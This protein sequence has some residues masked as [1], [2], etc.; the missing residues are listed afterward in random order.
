MTGHNRN[1]FAVLI[2]V[3]V[4]AGS[5][6]IFHLSQQGNYAPALVYGDVSTGSMTRHLGVLLQDVVTLPPLIPLGIR[7]YVGFFLATSGLLIAAGGGIGG[8]GMLVPIYNMIIGFPIKY[9]IA[10]ASI[11]VFGGAVA[12][13][14]LNASKPHPLHKVR[15]CI[16][17]ELILQMEP[18]TMAGALIGATLNK[19]LPDGPLVVL[20][21]VVLTAT[22]YK[23]FA[24]AI[25]LYRKESQAILIAEEDKARLLLVSSVDYGTTDKNVDIA[26][27]TQDAIAE[28]DDYRHASILAIVKLVLL[29]AVVTVLNMLKGGTYDGGGPFGLHRCDACC[30]YMVE[31]TILMVIFLFAY[32]VRHDLLNRINDGV[33]ISSDIDWDPYKTVKYPALSVVA[34]LVAGM[35]GVGGGIVKGPLML[36]L[37]VHPAVASAT[38]AAMILFTSSTATVSFACFDLLVYDYGAVCLATGFLATL[39]EIGRAHV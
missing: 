18:M 17:W 28:Q 22:S 1:P 25:K 5:A 34:G 4:I 36:A 23:T 19:V 12:N 13:N 20:F 24:T 16:D 9:A 30:A 35:F 33:K 27:L 7:D 10:L 6:T 21:L 14:V 26:I 8:G 31:V 15:S 3:A 37:G 2:T 32:W 29:F 39:I 11:T 38:S